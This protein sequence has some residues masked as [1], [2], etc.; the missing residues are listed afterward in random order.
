M[1]TVSPEITYGNLATAG[2]IVSGWL[3]F[4]AGLKNKIDVLNDR[5]QS[6]EGTINRFSEALIQ[7]AKQEVRLDSHAQRLQH[8]E[9]KL[10][11]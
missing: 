7:I 1:F 5:I 11:R 9:K 6:L 8:I 10:E 4:F 2:A 3:W